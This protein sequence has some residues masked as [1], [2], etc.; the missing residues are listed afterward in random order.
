MRGRV[1]LP[2]AW[3]LYALSPAKRGVPAVGGGRV[4]SRTITVSA[5]IAGDR[6]AVRVIVYDTRD[7]MIAA[8]QR[9]NGDTFEPDI[10]G[11]T[12]ARVDERRR[13]V[14][15]II[16]LWRECLG[17]RVVSHEMHHAV[18]A[19]YGAHVPDRLSRRAHLNHYNEP[20]AYLYSDLLARLVDRLHALGYYDDGA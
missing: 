10:I 12:Q 14:G 19:L 13:T 1:A 20:F 2:S 7:E 4:A 15:V 3:N 5:R 18:T 9:Y 11:V 16:R 8:A 6:E 17:T